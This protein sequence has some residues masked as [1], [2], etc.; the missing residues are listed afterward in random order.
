MEV[1]EQ[2]GQLVGS[3]AAAAEELRAELAALY[4]RLPDASFHEVSAVQAAAL[5]DCWL[6]PVAMTIGQ[7]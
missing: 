4:K 3:D 1:D 2:Q 6:W 7:V 5:S